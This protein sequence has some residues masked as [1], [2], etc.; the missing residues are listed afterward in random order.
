MINAVTIFTTCGSEE[1]ALTIAAAVV[2]QGYAACVNILPSIK[3]YYYY[4][5]GTHLDEE[6]MLMIKTSRDRYDAVAQ[7]I[8][9]LHTYEIPEILMVPVEA[10]SDSFLE[11]IEES[12]S[13][14]G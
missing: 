13:R 6:V 1:T 9:E 8:T 2:D 11:W 3:S 5:G 14:E 4:K 10:C 12:V 7:V